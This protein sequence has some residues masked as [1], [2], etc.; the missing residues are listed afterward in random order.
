MYKLGFYVDK[1]IIYVNVIETN[2]K[3]MYLKVEGSEIVAY[4][5][6]RIRK[7]MIN[8]FISDNIVKFVDHINNDKR[9]ELYSIKES[10]VMLSGIKYHFT[11]LTG[12]KKYSLLIKGKKVY[13]NCNTGSDKEVEKIIKT[14][15][16]EQL[17]KYLKISFYKKEKEMNLNNHVYKIIYKTST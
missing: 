13:I 5:P 14:H 10:F 3:N 12:F 6:K 1:K 16:K 9:V 11:V 17:D 8:K 4:A 15:L 2:N 7:K